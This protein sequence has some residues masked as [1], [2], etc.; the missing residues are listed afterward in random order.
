M[1]GGLQDAYVGTDTTSTGAAAGTS[2]LATAVMT[3]VLLLLA[4]RSG[5]APKRIGA[6]ARG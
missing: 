6:P 1:L 2:V 4:R 3:A 5:I